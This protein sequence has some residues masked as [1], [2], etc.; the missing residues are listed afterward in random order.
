MRRVLFVVL[1]LGL[2]VMPTQLVMAE[3][4]GHGDAQHDSTA[5]NAN[6]DHGGHG[7]QIEKMDVDYAAAFWTIGIFVLLLLILR[8]AAWK[9]VQQILVK[10]EAFIT[11]SLASAKRER[12]EAEQLLKQYAEQ[13]QKAKEEAAAIIE[14][15]RRDAE[16]VKVKVQQEARA[17]H[18][19]IIDRARRDVEIARDTA[20]K[21]LYDQTARL[22]TEVAGLIIE[23]EL[24]P[25]DHEK[26]VADSIQRLNALKSAGN[27]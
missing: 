11:D 15:G 6:G 20:V 18:D 23:K 14:E 26:L 12:E 9:P 19:A 2:W 1:A 4:G 24:K 16:A 17:E 5:H 8:G 10:R 3:S 25:A 7:P 27:N 13:I 22:A 21:S